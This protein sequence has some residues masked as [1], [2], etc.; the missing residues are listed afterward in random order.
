[1]PTFGVAIRAIAARQGARIFRA[2]TRDIQ[3]SATS[4]AVSVNRLSVATNRLGGTFGLIARSAAGFLGSIAAIAGIRST[5]R[6]IAEFDEATTRARVI[7]ELTTKQFAPFRAEFKK[8]AVDTR[9]TATQ[10]ADFGAELA[11]A[12]FRGRDFIS[13]LK[14][15]LDLA[16]AGAIELSKAQ[17]IMIGTL[18]Q[19][20]LATS[21]ATRIAN[22]F[23][24]AS[25]LTAASIEDI[26]IASLKAAPLARRVGLSFEETTAILAILTENIRI[27]ARAGTNFRGV[28]ASLLNPSKQVA[29]RFEAIG[30]SSENLNIIGGKVVDVLEKMGIANVDVA[31]KVKL[32]GRESIVAGLILEESADQFRGLSKEL[33]NLG[34]FAE[35]AAKK[36][37]NTLPGAFRR[38]ISAVTE[39]QLTLGEEGLLGSMRKT[40]DFIRD[41]VLALKGQE[42][43]FI[44]STKSVLLAKEAIVSFSGALAFLGTVAAISGIAAMVLAFNPVTVV[45]GAVV[46]AIILLRNE[47][48]EVGGVTTTVASV[49][50]VA[51]EEVARAIRN[52]FGIFIKTIKASFSLLVE[53]R[54]E[55]KNM[56]EAGEGA[57]AGMGGFL[58]V[59]IAA[60]KA[61]QEGKPARDSVIN[62]GLEIFNVFGNAETASERF[63]RRLKELND[64][65]EKL[66][67]PQP[68]FGPGVTPTGGGVTGAGQEAAKV[69]KEL[70][71]QQRSAIRFADDLGTAM[72][73]AFGDII[74]GAETAGQA[75]RNL[76]DKLAEL[77][78]QQVLLQ[79]LANAISFGLVSTLGGTAAFAP[80]SLNPANVFIPGGG[81]RFGAGSG[82]S[83][84][85]FQK[86]GIIG[87]P[88]FFRDG[89]AGEAGPE[90][91]LPLK[92]GPDGDLGVSLAGGSSVIVNMSIQTPNADSFRKSSRQIFSDTR[93]LAA[94]LK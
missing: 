46:A 54:K 42:D 16:A 70:T 79:P 60:Q 7:M 31:T 74:R 71:D 18:K 6:T 36:F 19:W 77:I 15:S 80:A 37:E 53:T 66:K 10:I 5:I 20:G 13:V 14:P 52:V 73:D 35:D 89:L 1:M 4:A 93:R 9:F 65:L 57:A 8:L 62:F 86:G 17:N 78:L 41:V 68:E 69:T 44:N 38:M 83:I 58:N 67:K 49:M 34:T 82:G 40:V 30:I 3:A 56:Q 85:N 94:R 61:M 90:A 91:I 63:T 22:V 88:T 25:F 29:E 45:V 32:L 39:A 12:G 21:E 47:T 23:T 28:M 26:S 11:Q 2:A 43:G 59:F 64:E 87:G 51:W 48:V 75:I 55:L 84:R 81:P 27:A 92:R 24:K 76:I 50:I 72:T 33:E